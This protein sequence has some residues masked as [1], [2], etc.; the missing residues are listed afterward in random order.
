MG[1]SR[2][3][4]TTKIHA[5]VDANGLPVALKLTEGQA[6]DG[7]SAADMLPGPRRRPNPDRRPRLRQRLFSA[8]NMTARAS[9]P[10]SSRWPAGF[11]QT[12]LQP[13]PVPQSR[14][15]VERFFDKLKHFRA[16]ATR[17]EKHAANYLVLFKLA[18]TRI[19]MRLNQSG[20]QESGASRCAAFA[21]APVARAPQA[22]MPL[23]SQVLQGIPAAS[24]DRLVGAD[25]LGSSA[26]WASPSFCF[27]RERKSLSATGAESTAA[28]DK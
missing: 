16:V 13:L 3:G 15:R 12:R 2:G 18:A 28:G 22:A 4:L 10:T 20:V 26:N 17:Y 9:S 24:C 21:R 1:R 19:C 11:E 25:R 23:H 5:L 27:R 6:H 14:N 8:K 7:R